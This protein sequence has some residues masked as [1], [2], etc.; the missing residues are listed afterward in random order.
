M[1]KLTVVA[2]VAGVALGLA[3]LVGW[4]FDIDRLKS[5]AP[6]FV[7][8]KANTAL[9]FALSGVALLLLRPLPSDLSTARRTTGLATAG[10]VLLIGAV[11]LSQDLFGFDLGI[12][13]LL[14]V[15]S[16]VAP[17]T[18]APG[19]MAP[20]SALCFA[21]LGA[22]LLLLAA[23]SRRLANLAQAAAA[24]VLAAGLLALMG[25]LYGVQELHHLVQDATAMALHTSTGFIV[26][27]LGAILAHAQDGWMAIFTSR[28]LG[29]VV[30]R[31]L[32]PALVIVI[33][34]IGGL[35][36]LGEAQGLYSSR[37]GAA[38]FALATMALL[39]VV[40]WRT[41]LAVARLDEA[42]RRAEREVYEQRNW[43]E[44]TLIS[45]GDAVITTDTRG[46]VVFLNRVAEQLTAWTT[47]EAAGRPLDEVFP[48]VHEMTGETVDN[49][50]GRVLREGR[51]VGLANHTVLEGR[52]GRR[53]PIEDS[54][55]PIRDEDGRII[56]VVLVFRDV[57][58]ERAAE[59]ELRAS[60][61]LKGAIIESAI[62][63][64]I[65]MDHEGRI[66][67]FNPAAERMFGYSREEIIGQPLA[68][69]IIPPELRAKHYEGL[70]HFLDT[71]EGP[72]LGRR[73]EVPALRANGEE[74]PVE[75]AIVRIPTA[76]PPVF[77]GHI[78]DISERKRAEEKMRTIMAELNHRVKNTLAVIQSIAQQTMRRSP[79]YD[80][81]QTAF[82]SRLRALAAAH[83]LITQ[84]QW[85]GAS[86]HDIIDSELVARV[87]TKDQYAV[88]GPEISLRPK[89]ALAMHMVVHELVTNAVKYGALKSADG[90][91][92]VQWTAPNGSTADARLALEWT[93]STP[94]KISPPRED[95]YG[96]RLIAR[97]VEYD[98]Q[99][100]I[101]REFHESGLRCRINIPLVES[102]A[103]RDEELSGAV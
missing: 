48:I 91:V 88:D 52:D 68:E 58:K 94:H 20:N 85:E 37:Y 71:G 86:L 13:E 46:R 65:T 84:T 51:V 3:V 50:V 23:R 6:A 21:V 90:R 24:F 11:T 80:T 67:E 12:D 92:V 95:G 4:A 62:D 39:G 72:V 32:V 61:A 28:T 63:G 44:T 103:E 53:T 99:G 33:M 77:T 89:M 15:D 40:V 26:L 96:S 1:A 79:D 31:R 76:G 17:R 54:A 42:R 64:L 14:F 30:A 102:D 93:E 75:I 18:G 66:V 97:L 41:A 8:M 36:V 29:G 2:G 47:N 100:V 78:Q 7:T 69:L 34:V 83:S 57:T 45:I 59:N 73:I 74:F 43:L 16:A 9:A 35:R 5:V 101:E 82:I 38:L 10:L 55:A 56:G 70:R 22:S 81:F 49:P 19:R 60:E 27:G 98:L 87:D 25:Y